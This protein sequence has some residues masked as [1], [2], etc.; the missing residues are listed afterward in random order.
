MVRELV[1]ASMRSARREGEAGRG[2]RRASERAEEGGVWG[3][4][5]A[6][7]RVE[8]SAS[9]LKERSATVGDVVCLCPA[10]RT[11]WVGRITVVPDLRA[12]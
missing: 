11:G 7:R 9:G 8:G 5:V 4:V 3:P 12:P 6:M 1:W 2:R 10:M